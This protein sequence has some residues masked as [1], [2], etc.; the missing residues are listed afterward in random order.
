MNK[1]GIDVS[2]WQGNIDFEKVA[3]AGI[4]YAFIKATDGATGRDA[5][6]VEN[7]KGARAA[8][9]IT[10]AYHYFRALS[11]T[12]EAQKD[13]VVKTLAAAGFDSS[14]ELFLVDA[15]LTGNQ[16]ATRDEMADALHKLLVLLEKE[17]IFGGR[18]PFI[19]CSNDFW[20]N[21]ISSDKY[22]FSAYP[23]WIAHWNVNEPAVPATW[24][25]AG[26]SWSIWQHSSKGKVDG[27]DGNVD[28]DW[29]RLD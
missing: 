9:I 19:Y 20:K 10:G 28:L 11:S 2:H 7:R 18:K 4:E 5:K 3:G 16:K 26:K 27:I 8:G 1:K 12:P 14:S 24:T 21:Y 22:D 15:E 6:Y 29:V 17:V 23:L 13:N 25:N